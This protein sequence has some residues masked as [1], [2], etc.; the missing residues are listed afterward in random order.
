MI[1]KTHISAQQP[2][3]RQLNAKVCG[4]ESA[5]FLILLSSDHNVQQRY[6]KNCSSTHRYFITK[7]MLITARSYTITQRL[8]S[9]KFTLVDGA[10]HSTAQ[11]LSV[12]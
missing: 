2:R 7:L 11:L 3:G 6:L 4:S 10:V 8:H 12:A 1:S 5:I 9:S